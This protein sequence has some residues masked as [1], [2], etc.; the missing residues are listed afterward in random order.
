MV[1]YE[2]LTRKELISLVQ[3]K[4]IP[5]E[6]DLYQISKPNLIRMLISADN[7]TETNPV[8]ETVA[9]VI[10]TKKLE[11]SPSAKHW[12]EYLKKIKMTPESFLERFPNHKYK[13]YILEIVNAK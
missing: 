7:T 13:N 3:E 12:K 6:K 2:S 4:Q 1:T 5:Y 8:T 9:E 10:T 11:L